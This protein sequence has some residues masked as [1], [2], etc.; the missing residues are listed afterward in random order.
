MDLQIAGGQPGARKAEIG[1]R[2]GL[3][4]EE[5]TV[6]AQRPLEVADRKRDVAQP[7]SEHGSVMPRRARQAQEVAW[8]VLSYV[9]F[10]L[11]AAHAWIDVQALHYMFRRHDGDS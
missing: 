9:K 10:C 3:E 6:E 8:R 2:N 11:R 1:P 5:V 4:T 7:A